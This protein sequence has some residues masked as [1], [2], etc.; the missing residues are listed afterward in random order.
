MFKAQS[1][2]KQYSSNNNTFTIDKWYEVY[3]NVG[4]KKAYELQIGDI[5]VNST[6][7]GKVVEVEKDDNSIILYLSDFSK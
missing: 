5:L 4:W 7:Q 6:E 2:E 1:G 3:T